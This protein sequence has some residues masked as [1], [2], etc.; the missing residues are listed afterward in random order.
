M[1]REGPARP[2]SKHQKRAGICESKAATE[3]RVDP[4][5]WRRSFYDLASA[6]EVKNTSHSKALLRVVKVLVHGLLAALPGCG[7][8]SRQISMVVLPVQRKIRRCSGRLPR[9]VV[10]VVLQ[11]PTSSPSLNAITMAAQ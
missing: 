5:Q 2:V 9:V 4:T 6:V 7:N 8:S 3:S 1:T 10:A 11:L